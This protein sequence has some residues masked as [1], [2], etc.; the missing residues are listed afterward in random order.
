MRRI[1]KYTIV[2]A[3]YVIAIHGVQ[4]INEYPEN[5]LPYL[6]EKY[7]YPESDSVSEEHLKIIKVF[8]SKNEMSKVNSSIPKKITNI[9]LHTDG[10][11]TLRFT[12]SIARHIGKVKYVKNNG[13]WKETEKF[14]G[15]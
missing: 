12:W 8:I 10:S 1:L 15:F 13:K 14:F 7:K 2:I 3:S 4:A 11:A 5:I 9:K 6:S